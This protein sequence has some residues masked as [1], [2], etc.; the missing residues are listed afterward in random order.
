MMLNDKIAIITGSS[1]GI[2]R[3][4]AIGLAEAGA[5]VTVN[6]NQNVDKAN[7]V[8]N[9]VSELG[10]RALV[11]KSDVSKKSDVDRMVKLTLEEFGKIDIVYG[12]RTPE[13]LCFVKEF[14]A[15]RKA[16]RTDL[17]LTVDAEAPGWTGQV[18]FVPQIVGQLALPPRSRTVIVCGPP[19]MIK[20][21]LADLETA[22]YA[23]DD[24]I[25]TLEL[26]MKC[27]VGKCG[28]CNLG[29]RYVCRDGPVFRLSEIKALH[30]EF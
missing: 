7:S 5:N 30:G 14:D 8:A 22:G 6:C 27:G 9:K 17:H 24:I 11:V 15:W 13:L 19:I 20:F 1:Q 4:I 16:P 3:G 12:A 29:P 25:T 18:G 28:R 23:D 10:H 21:V 26:K 2:G